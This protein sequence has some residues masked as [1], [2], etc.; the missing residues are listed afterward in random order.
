MPW[1]VKSDRLQYE[2]LLYLRSDSFLEV[3][4]SQQALGVSRIDYQLTPK[5][6]LFGRMVLADLEGPSAY[7]EKKCVDI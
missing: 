1:W 5:P 3:P 6:S 2:F 7:D 4:F